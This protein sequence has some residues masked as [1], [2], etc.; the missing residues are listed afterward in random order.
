VYYLD[1]FRVG[2]TYADVALPLDQLPETMPP[3]FTPAGGTFTNRIDVSISC[4]STG[5]TIRYTTDGTLPSTNNGAVYAAPITL[6]RPTLLQAIAQA[7]G[8]TESSIAGARFGIENDIVA[9]DSFEDYPAGPLAGRGGG[10]GFLAPYAAL[11]SATVVSRSMVYAGGT[12]TVKGGARALRVDGNTGTRHMGREFYPQ[13]GRRLYLSFL[14][15]HAQSFSDDDFFCLGLQTNPDVQPEA[16]VQHRVNTN[17]T[18]L[19]FGIRYGGGSGSKAPFDTVSGRV[20]FAVLRLEKSVPGPASTYDR[21]ALFLN[22]LSPFEAPVP[23]HTFTNAQSAA[24]NCLTLRTDLLGSG[25][26]YYVDNIRVGRT[27]A[28]V[29][30][31]ARG[32]VLV[33]R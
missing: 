14:F 27:Y 2:T 29:L 12:L 15:E 21:L 11:T 20:Y 10:E 33:L 1:Q 3:V 28:S 22:P 26:A 23:T 24:Y 7:P 31:P 30:P 6:A 19:G 5:A 25:A 18:A 8:K 32:A 9:A 13:S 17:G 4:A 16:G